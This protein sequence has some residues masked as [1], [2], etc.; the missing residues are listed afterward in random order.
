MAVVVVVVVAAVAV[1]VQTINNYGI[2]VSACQHV[3]TSACQIQNKL[4][5]KVA[6]VKVPGVSGTDGREQSL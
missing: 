5:H 6:P 3:S 4:L 2:T 1:A